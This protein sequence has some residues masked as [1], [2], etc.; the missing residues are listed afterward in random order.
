MEISMDNSSG[1]SPLPPQTYAASPTGSRK[2]SVQEIDTSTGSPESRKSLKI[3]DHENQE[4]RDPSISHSPTPSIATKTSNTHTDSSSLSGPHLASTPG[5][6]H[7]GATNTQNTAQQSTPVGSVSVTIPVSRTMMDSYSSNTQP[8]TPNTNDAST[9]PV[10]KRKLSPA[11]KEAKQQEKAAKQQEK[12]AKQQEKEAKERQRLE[13]KAKK[14]EE[15]RI[16]EEEK[17]KREAEREEE[18]KRR[19]EKKKLKEEEKA[20]KDEEKRK[21]EEEKLKK[22]RAQTKLN[23][24]FAKPKTP[25]QVGNTR[26]SESPKK[27]V[28]GDASSAPSPQKSATARSDYQR[29]FPDFFLQSHTTVAPPHRFQHDS[30]ALSHIRERVDV[31]LKSNTNG[32]VQ[33]LSLRPSEIFQIMPYK[34]RRG[35]QAASVKDILLEMQ[36]QNDQ[37]G[38]DCSL[39]P[40]KLLKEI[41]MKS[42]KFGEDVRPPY[43]GTFTQTVPEAVAHKLMRNPFHRGLP[44]ANYDYDSEAEWEEPEEGED[45]ESEEEEEGSDEGEDDMDGFLDDDDDGLIDGKRRLL[46]GDLEPVCT[47]L[48]WQGETDEQDL[49]MYKIQTVSDSVSLPIDPFSTA[50]WEK[51]KPT[52]H[53]PTGVAGRSTLHSFMVIPASTQSQTVA[54]MVEG[55]APTLLTAGGKAKRALTPEQLAEFKQAVNGSDLTKT[56]LIEVL[57]KRF[58]KVSKDVLKET[59]NQVATRVGQKEADKKWVCKE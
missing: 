9:P 52:E 46:V 13:E 2:R 18:R 48:R 45:L 25:A 53:T 58:P 8:S 49:E 28:A 14:E 16:K 15:K 31:C 29:E 47:G 54:S 59:L 40:Q 6:P 36:T 17:K 37:P 20:A 19:D 44:E 26:A 39:R 50:Y 32:S 24:F 22:E 10:K 56:G 43:Q 35:R 27:P 11:S 7:A 55:A 23:A 41:R 57:K 33:P 51:P 34:R 21:K 4:N 5:S 1:L 3:G 42:L 12:E 30:Q 38:S